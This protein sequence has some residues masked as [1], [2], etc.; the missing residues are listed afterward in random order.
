MTIGPPTGKPVDVKISGDD[1][2][3][4]MEIASRV[5]GFLSAQPGVSAA[6]SNLV[7]GK[8]EAKVDIDERKAG[9]FGIDKWS[10]AR[11][12]K[13]LG[14]GL[15]VAKTRVGE[16]EAEINLRY[17]RE[18]SG[19]F[20]VKSHQIPT[21]FGKR[22]PIGTVAE[23][24]DSKTPLEIRRENL[25]RTVTVTAEVDAQTTTSREVNANLSRHLVSLLENYP[26]Y[27]FRFAGEEEQYT[28][29]ISDIK[30]RRFW[31]CFSFISFSQVYCAPP[32]SPL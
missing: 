31:L 23:I 27:S 29:A 3:V 4:L 32:F 13:A 5:R 11:E 16:E 7:Y 28:Q 25:R 22:V 8:P 26:G 19:V 15:T 17:G 24:A 2:P 21:P 12:I 18:E 10:V 30:R 6:T 20:S 1:I 14:D 9:V